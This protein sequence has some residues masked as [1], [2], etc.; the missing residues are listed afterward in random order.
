[1]GLMRGSWQIGQDQSSNFMILLSIVRY[2]MLSLMGFPGTFS[3]DEDDSIDV[4]GGRGGGGM[5]RWTCNRSS[6]GPFPPSDDI[7]V[8]DVVVRL[9]RPGI[10]TSL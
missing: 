9:P 7:V 2:L 1:M 3:E 5:G 8:V 6:S 4:D 10:E